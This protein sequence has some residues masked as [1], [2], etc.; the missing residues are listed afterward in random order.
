MNTFASLW[1]FRSKVCGVVLPRHSLVSFC[2]VPLAPASS[3][4]SIKTCM[5][6]I[7][8]SSAK[9]TCP[10]TVVY[11]SL[12]TPPYGR[13]CNNEKMEG[14]KCQ[15]SME[16]DVTTAATIPKSELAMT[17]GDDRVA[18]FFGDR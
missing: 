17:R 10:G 3:A 14:A 4:V 16:C 13:I 18:F 9:N 12:R 6:V 2:D 1:E 5:F 7:C 11:Y 8:A 15:G